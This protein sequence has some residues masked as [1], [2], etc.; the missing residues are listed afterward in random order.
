MRALALDALSQCSEGVAS[1]QKGEGYTQVSFREK[2]GL[3]GRRDRATHLMHWYPAK[4][5]YRIPDQILEA[6]KPRDHAVLLDPFCG[7]G[8]VLV[9]GMLRGYDAIG[10]DINPLAKLISRVKTRPIDTDLISVHAAEIRASAKRLR[11]CPGEHQLPSFWFRQAPR[12][13]LHH[14]HRAIAAIEQR[15]YREFFLVCLSN[16]VRRCSIADPSIPPPVRMTNERAK[17]AGSRYRTNL[18]AA[19]KLDR[20]GVFE[21]FDQCVSDNTDRIY[22]L[23]QQKGLGHTRII[24]GSASNTQIEGASVDVIITSP[25]Y[26]GAQKYV[27]S[28]NLEMKLLGYGAC[29]IADVDRRTLGTERV[30]KFAIPE[31]SRL[32]NESRDTIAAVGAKN[33]VRASMLAHYLNGLIDFSLEMRRVLRPRAN[34]F[35]S[36]GTSKIAGIDVD[37]ADHFVEIARTTGFQA[38]T[39]LTDSIPSRG[40]ITKRHHTSSTIAQENVVWLRAPHV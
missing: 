14:L 38:V 16:I 21:L 28:L 1:F 7:S 33:G 27:R 6:V 15:P 25:P 11:S 37:L 10:I 4:M 26:C 12:V 18:D 23:A 22:N 36:F 32:P 5:F 8:T 13:A 30:S 39:V 20:N 17:L 2:G 40:M 31:L 35:V 9:E 19:N 34:A 24:D 29:A 3:V